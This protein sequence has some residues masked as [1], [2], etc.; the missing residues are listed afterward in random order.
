MR[1]SPFKPKILINKTGKDV[2]FMCGGITH[3]HK[4]G[5]KVPYDGETANHAL[6]EVNTGL[7]E[8][9]E[10]PANPVG[11]PQKELEDLKWT[12]LLKK[13]SREGV[14]E[15]GMDKDTIITALRAKNGTKQTD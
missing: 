14:Y 2:E 8:Y 12:S 15:P 10:E 7:E 6:T 11:R 13:A 1:K 3:I 5:E 9:V 4:V